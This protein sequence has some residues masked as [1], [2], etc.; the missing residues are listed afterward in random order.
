MAFVDR[1]QIH[2]EGGR[3]GAGSLSFRREAH[4]PRGGPDGGNGGRGGQVRLVG[5]PTLEDLNEFRNHVHHKAGVGGAGGGRN[6]RGAAGED[7]AVAVPLGTRVIRDGFEIAE[8]DVADQVVEVA[9]GGDGGV[10]NRAFR[11]STHRAPRETVP[12]GPGEAAWL[13]LELRKPVAVA[14]VGLPNCGKSTLMRA[15]TGARVVIGEYPYS[16]I[17]PAFGTMEDEAG[18]L[19]LVADVPGLDALEFHFKC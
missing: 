6:R 3:G 15:L 19:Y 18:H 16:T 10:G 2:V 14:L 17:D 13:T 8:I 12:A 5:D 1:V 4:V 9:R 7:L 11:S